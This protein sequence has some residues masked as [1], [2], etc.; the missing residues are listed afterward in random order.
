MY[1]PFRYGS[2][3]EGDFFTDRVHDLAKSIQI[4]QSANH[5]I[6]ISPRR[7]GKTSLIN[8][9]VA[10]LKR[11]T[12]SLNLQLVTSIT[13]L[14]TELLK[15][16]LAIYPMEKAKYFLKNFRIAPIIS[17]NPVSNALDVSFA[18]T[19]SAKPILEDVLTLIEALGKKGKRPL[20]VF[21]EFQEVRS[22]DKALDKQLRSIIQLH[23]NVNYVFMGSQESLMREIFE[24]KKSPFYHFGTLQTLDLIPYA[25]FE[26]FL[27]KG[28]SP[29][30]KNAA[31]I[32]TTILQLTKQHPYYTQMLAFHYFNA[33]LHSKRATLQE[34]IL[35]IIREHD[36]DYERLWMG[37]NLK[38]RELILELIYIEKQLRHGKNNNIPNST[39]YSA[40]K[41]LL[42]KG[43]LIQGKEGYRVEDPF[44]TAWILEQ[45]TTSKPLSVVY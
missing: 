26:A 45:R 43:F 33:L 1:N 7:Y 42:S 37:L 24:R 20:V 34:V 27:K 36:I 29:L 12:I 41:R 25:D 32:A 8:K 38:D 35:S 22:I 28:F 44:F 15:R 2:V 4:I 6:L 39:R 18:P 5:L 19:L 14:A 30:Y 3:V 40:Y 9:A 17:L 11:P 10:Q 23:Q 21:D 16:I 13:D 31:S